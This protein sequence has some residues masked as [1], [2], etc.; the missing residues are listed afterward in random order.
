M[1]VGLAGLRL[2]WVGLARAWPDGRAALCGVG[3]GLPVCYCR[4]VVDL[5]IF[6]VVWEVVEEVDGCWCQK[7]LEYKRC[8]VLP[9]SH[10]L[11]SKQTTRQTDGVGAAGRAAGGCRGSEAAA[12]PGPGPDH[13]CR[14][15]STNVF[16]LGVGMAWFGVSCFRFS[17]SVVRRGILAGTNSA[18]SRARLPGRKRV[19][20][21][22]HVGGRCQLC[23]VCSR[24]AAGHRV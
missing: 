19:P 15:L 12:G 4:K 16:L 20:Y 13:A 21:V 9:D 17:V 1:G 18:E 2:G 6:W 5:M 24:G 8:L 23:R 22:G 3:V 10:R 14:G 7:C 11:T